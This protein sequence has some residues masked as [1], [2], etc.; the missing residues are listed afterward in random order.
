MIRGM[1][2]GPARM[3]LLCVL[4]LLTLL[5]PAPA[6]AD[7]SL[8]AD[9]SNLLPNGDFESIMNGKPVDWLPFN[10]LYAD[11]ASSAS[12]APVYSGT[13]SVKVTDHY[14][15]V[16]SGLRS[17]FIPVTPGQMY[18]ASAY[19]YNQ[20]GTSELYLEFWNSAKTRLSVSIV[21]N[22]TSNEWKAME[23]EAAVPADAAFA[24]VLL[25]QNGPN[26]GTTYFDKTTLQEILPNGSME[27]VSGGKPT[28]WTPTNTS[29]TVYESVL[30][31]NP[32]YHGTYST[33]LTDASSLGNG[34]RS[35]FVSVY[36]GAIYEASVYSYNESGTS[37][38]YLEFWNE[39]KQR[40][41]VVIV[42]NLKTNQ[43]ERLSTQS[44]VPAGAV[45][46]TV[47]L[48]QNGPNTGTAYFDMA[49]FRALPPEPEVPLAVNGHPRLYFTSSD[50]PGIRAKA[51]DAANR[52]FGKTGK[53]IWDAIELKARNY[54][55]ET[56]MTVSYYGG[57]TVTYALPP[58]MPEYMENP[59]GY[60]SGRYP[61]WTAY[62]SG[63]RDRLET[64]SWAYIVTQ[65]QPF[66]DRAKAYAL[67][68]AGWGTWND[69]SYGCSGATCLDTAHLTFGVSAAY[70][71][72][73]DQY[74]V[75]ERSLLE[76]A[77]DGKGLAPLYRDIAVFQDHN[78]LALRASAL[79]SG[80][81]ALLGSK[82]RAS[83]YLNRAIAYFD[84]YFDS[85]MESGQQEGIG[86]TSFSME[87]IILA[88]DSVTRV[89][90]IPGLI[91]HP[92]LND[93]VVRWT[94]YFLAPGGGGLANF[95]D[96]LYA[97][98]FPLTMNVIHS[99]LDNGEAGWY[100]AETN[101]GNTTLAGFMYF[102]PN[103]TVTPP[104]GP[105]SAVLDEIGWAALRSGW[106]SND[107]LLA[108]ISNDSSMGHNHYDQNSFQLATNGT[109]IAA[110][111][112]YQD[113][114]PGP[115]NEF[116]VRLGHSTIQVD[117]MGQSVKGGGQLSTGLL[118]PAY[119]YVK[120]SAAEA[121]Q[122]PLLRKYDRHIV[123]VKPHY[124]VMLDELQAD[125]PRDFDWVMFNG[126]Q[127]EFKIDGL[128][129]IPGEQRLGSRLNVRKGG[130][131]LSVEYLAEDPLSI[132]IGQYPG[133]E[134]YGDFVKVR[135]T[136][137][138]SAQG[139][140]LTVLQAKPLEEAGKL[141]ET[142][143]VPP[144]ATSG[145]EYRI[146]TAAGSNLL[147]YR[148]DGAG[149]FITVEVEVP[150]DGM[151]ELRSFFLKSPSYGQ[152]Q[153]SIDGQPIGAVYD[154]Y[155]S[156]VGGSRPFSHGSVQL[157]AGTHQ[158]RYEVIGKNP[159]SANY[160]IGIDAIQLETDLQTGGYF[161]DAELV[162]GTGAI[163]AAVNRND[164]SGITDKVLFRTGTG[165]Y[166]LAGITSNAEQTV[167]ST[168]YGGASAGYSMTRGNMLQAGGQVLL[169]AS[170]SFS[171]A[172][173]VDSAER[174][175]KG[176]IE[177]SAAQT[178]TLHAPYSGS[179]FVNGQL[180]PATQYTVN[181]IAGTV[182]FSLTA[183]RYEIEILGAL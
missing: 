106:E 114:V 136:A 178:V 132:A 157:T 86:Y 41:S 34:V 51:A 78:L 163:G 29:S 175:V 76:H 128:Q 144:V 42:K 72:L 1:P 91:E 19:S 156:T 7:S 117:G 107:T 11:Y 168:T 15:H 89:T 120:G 84:W 2:A 8:P 62:A 44:E 94:N 6:S 3:M 88:V 67:S 69:P 4:L 140:F 17:A 24:T 159:L 71:I 103:A 65:E 48:Y 155:A 60:T 80:A 70:D 116:T 5:P 151:Y 147:F 79:A 138:K 100:L 129:A 16:G 124:Y 122:N 25:Y 43:W 162:Q 161:A 173:D 115:N 104:A 99:W 130:A 174:K 101:A 49:S 171:A 92:F 64:L 63:I 50:I 181:P 90:A 35:S 131:E 108:F 95:S 45:Y 56:T 150:E 26:L 77:I 13:S 96:S 127:S 164:G 158:I 82:D 148:A 54:L 152:V 112:G 68:V 9:P 134:K 172:L 39:A 109:W 20:S 30:A 123:F 133:A 170:N 126:L 32:V 167:V 145:K 119:D 57:H 111:P 176:V 142:A 177:L 118:A 55:A 38:M 141:E 121:Y 74:T 73:Y 139:K 146:I 33:K 83:A 59:P 160:Y 52:P 182:S 183:G 46:A 21:K 66:A 102:N 37:E 169:Q 97:H 98:Y 154:G 81:S 61:Y 165:T 137:A 12:P 143:L 10:H 53:E 40:L 47:L 58:E 105:A 87:N 179:V 36:T 149:D 113:Y 180:L 135:S 153:A 125:V 110:D 18:H 28:G 31:P 93:F 22:L 14:N 75:E 85:K 23:T 166:T 27:Q